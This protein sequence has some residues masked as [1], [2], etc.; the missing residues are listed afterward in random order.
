[1]ITLHNVL[2]HLS[3]TTTLLDRHDLDPPILETKMS[4]MTKVTAREM[5]AFFEHR[6]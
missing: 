6:Q 5:Q 2:I 1:M 4:H 3:L